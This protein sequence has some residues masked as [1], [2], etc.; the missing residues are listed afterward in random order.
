MCKYFRC[1][2]LRG[3][4]FTGIGISEWCG[5]LDC[6]GEGRPPLFQPRL[7]AGIIIFLKV[8]RNLTFRNLTPGQFLIRALAEARN[9]PTSIF[10]RYNSVGQYWTPRP[11]RASP[12]L[13]SPQREFHR[14]SA[15]NKFSFVCALAILPAFS[16]TNTV[17]GA[18]YS[19]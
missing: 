19:A 7:N 9:P 17:V 18:G 16:Q 8:C 10:R 4:R 15:M 1:E 14:R 13:F 2:H 3:V 11:Q 12:A 5:R 6:P